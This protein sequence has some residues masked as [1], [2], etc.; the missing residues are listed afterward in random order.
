[1]EILC[2]GCSPKNS[3]GSC[4]SEKPN[5]ACD[6]YIK[7]FN[8]GMK[9]LE[10]PAQHREA[11]VIDS[12]IAEHGYP[13]EF[14]EFAAQLNARKAEQ[15]AQE[16]V[17]FEIDWPE[18]NSHAMGCGLED[19]GITSRYEA[20][21]YGWDE[22]LERMAECLP[23]ELYTSPPAQQEPVSVTYKEVFDS[24]NVL[25]TGDIK[26]VQIAMAM[27]NK[28]LYT[29]PQPSKPWVGLTLEDK[30]HIIDN[31]FGGSRA[32]CMD[33]AEKILREKNA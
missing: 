19:R 10:Q 29:S 4:P 25:Y 33:E 6:C 18:Y 15:P 3:D 20:M 21:Q 13:K 9:E 24:M 11:A 28:K 1:M 22:A 23:D 26:Q 5:G 30:Q 32:D 17:V 27:E 7:G 2:I 8:D 16:P 12:I 31:N 14:Q